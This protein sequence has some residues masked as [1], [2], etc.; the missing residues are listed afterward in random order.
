MKRFV[1]TLLASVAGYTT[2]VFFASPGAYPGQPIAAVRFAAR[3][4]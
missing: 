3:S 1:L 2:I 4:E